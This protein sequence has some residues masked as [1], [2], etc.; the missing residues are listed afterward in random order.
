MGHFDVAEQCF[1]EAKDMPSLFL[2]YTGTT[3]REGLEKLQG[4]SARSG[5]AN[6]N[7]LSSFLLVW[8]GNWNV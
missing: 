5:E 6:L 1:L 2:L 4:M 7:F 3:N 8:L